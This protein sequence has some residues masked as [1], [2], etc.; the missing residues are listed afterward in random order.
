MFATQTIR[1]DRIHQEAAVLIRRRCQSVSRS[2]NGTI[3]E[4]QQPPSTIYWARGTTS[5]LSQ[6]FNDDDIW[7]IDLEPNRH[8]QH[9]TT[10]QATRIV[11]GHDD[12]RDERISR[13]REEIGRRRKKPQVL[14][15]E[16]LDEKEGMAFDVD[17]V[18]GI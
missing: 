12:S 4:A 10:Q 5:L 15:K 17:K 1:L 16:E 8:G 13:E 3:P 2:C 6:R 14:S 18:Q 11:D 9:G 7:G